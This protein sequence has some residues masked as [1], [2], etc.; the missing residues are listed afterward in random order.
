MSEKY[1]DIEAEITISISTRVLAES[2][3][4]A[5]EEVDLADF[6]PES[7]DTCTILSADQ[8]SSSISS[9]ECVNEKKW[10]AMG[11]AEKITFLTDHSVDEAD[12]LHWVSDEDSHWNDIEEYIHEIDCD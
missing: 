8:V 6:C 12:A 7:T 11:A 1:Y 10:D 9:C 3:Y 4:D 5:K 2:E